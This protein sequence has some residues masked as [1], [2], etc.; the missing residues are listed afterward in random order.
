MVS[1]E[2]FGMLGRRGLYSSLSGPGS[3][4]GAKRPCTGFA[5]CFPQ[6]HG[7]HCSVVRMLSIVRLFHLTA[8]GMQWGKHYDVGRGA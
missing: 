7:V 3:T 1:S 6:Q 8:G 4:P 5:C 2:Y